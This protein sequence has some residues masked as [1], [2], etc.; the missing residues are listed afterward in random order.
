VSEWHGF[1]AMKHADGL[2]SVSADYG[3]SDADPTPLASVRKQYPVRAALRGTD[4]VE[5]TEDELRWLAE[6]VA[7]LVLKRM[8]ERP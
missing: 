2:V 7:P 1:P 3:G 4:F 5:L 8:G 6:D